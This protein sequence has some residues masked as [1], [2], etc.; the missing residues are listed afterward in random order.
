[1]GLL[2]VFVC[3]LRIVAIA[4]IYYHPVL[5]KYKHSRGHVKYFQRLTQCLYSDY[6]LGEQAVLPKMCN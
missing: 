5:I 1:M 6:V 2:C 3:K 4:F